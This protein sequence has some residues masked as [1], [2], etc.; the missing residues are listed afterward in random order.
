MLSLGPMPHVRVEDLP[1]ETLE[2]VFRRNRRRLAPGS[3]GERWFDEG[4]DDRIADQDVPAAWEGLSG[5]ELGVAVGLPGA[6]GS[7]RRV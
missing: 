4:V 5:V 7:S 3:W 1:L 2:R 6:G